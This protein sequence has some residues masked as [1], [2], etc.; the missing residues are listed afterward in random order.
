MN[1]ELT[2]A[3]LEEEWSPDD[4]FVWRLRQGAFDE[5]GFRRLVEILEQVD[6]GDS[7][8]IDRRLVSLIWMLPLVMRW[9][10]ERLVK[11][12]SDRVW[13]LSCV[14]KVEGLVQDILGVP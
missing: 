4:G 8:T 10:E 11:H 12:D 1:I 5:A 13:Y 14:G 9:Q 6:L 3:L 2:K 7:P